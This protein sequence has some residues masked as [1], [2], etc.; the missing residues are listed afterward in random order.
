MTDLSDPTMY[1]FGFTLKYFPLPHPRSNPT[2]P[3]GRSRRKRSTIGHG[4]RFMPVSKFCPI[5]IWLFVLVQNMEL[6]EDIIEY[7][8]TGSREMR[9]NVLVHTMHMLH[10]VIFGVVDVHLSGST[11]LVWCFPLY[12]VG[13]GIGGK[14][15]RKVDHS[16]ENV[17]PLAPTLLAD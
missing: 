9:G 1:K 2:A 4:C 16:G 5:L 12:G 14:H 15:R 3:I 10:F 6:R 8:E 17:G 7:L 11:L 13:G